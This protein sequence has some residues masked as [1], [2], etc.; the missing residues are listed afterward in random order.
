MQ[1]MNLQRYTMRLVFRMRELSVITTELGANPSFDRCPSV[2]VA[3]WYVQEASMNYVHVDHVTKSFSVMSGVA[4]NIYAEIEQDRIA[5]SFRRVSHALSKLSQR[6]PGLCA[7][8]Q[9][10][11][12]HCC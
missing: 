9:D 6:I 1:V 11:I 8:L 12:T 3:C 4:C 10:A 7:Y 5:N 2:F